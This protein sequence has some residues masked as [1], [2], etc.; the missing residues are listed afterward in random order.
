MGNDSMRKY[1]YHRNRIVLSSPESRSRK[2]SRSFLIPVL[3]AAGL[4]L[5]CQQNGDDSDTLLLGLTALFVSNPCNFQ[6]SPTLSSVTPTVANNYPV[7]KGQVFQSDGQPAISALVVVESTTQSG[8]RFV[9]TFTG[10]DRTGSFYMAGLPNTTDQYR[11]AVEPIDSGLRN[12]IDAH[13]SCFQNPTSF[14]AGYYTGSN[15]IVN[16]NSGS[17]TT[18]TLNA[19][20]SDVYDAGNIILR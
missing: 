15:S 9:S 2:L 3:L 20:S 8:Q 16:T 19:S 13:I 14:T 11:I 10:I 4:L 5:Q 6:A 18:F 1:K 17:A 12:R 7:V